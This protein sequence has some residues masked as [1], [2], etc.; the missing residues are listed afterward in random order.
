MGHTEQHLKELGIVIP[1]VGK[2]AGNYVSA[3]TGGHL[4]FISGQGPLIDNEVVYKGVVGKDITQEDGYKAARI[5]GLNML[6]ALQ[7]EI[8]SLDRVKRVV[9]VLGWVSSAPDFTAQ[10]SVI[11]G[12]SDLLVEVL[13]ERGVHARSALSAHVLALG[14]AVE[15]E[16][17]VEIV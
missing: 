4:V 3:T 13:G 8:G 16:M 11:N 5:T 15:A 12:I 1:E 10:P 9:K 6:A 7:A 2:S 17:I 14:M